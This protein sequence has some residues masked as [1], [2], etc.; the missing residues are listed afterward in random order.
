MHACIAALSQNIPTVP[1]A[2]SDKFAGMMQ[3]IG[4]GELVADPRHMDAAAILE[5]V[6]KIYEKR[7]VVGRDLATKMPLVKQCIRDLSNGLSLPSKAD[8]RQEVYC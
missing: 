5:T 7:A 8:V 2:Y 3:S 6:D 1:I 4:F